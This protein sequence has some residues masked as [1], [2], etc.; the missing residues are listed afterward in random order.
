[1]T[2]RT[3]IAWPVIRLTLLTAIALVMT[4]PYVFMITTSF[5]PQSEVFSGGLNLIPS[6]GRSS[7]TTPRR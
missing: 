5:K 3:G 1:M 2:R 4:A 6:T 7:Q